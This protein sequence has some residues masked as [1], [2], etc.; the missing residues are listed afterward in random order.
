MINIGEVLLI[1]SSL[2]SLTYVIGAL[3]MALP[4]PLY[5]VKKWGTRL[6]TDGIYA[7]IWTDIYGLTM[8][9]IQYINNL[10]GASWSYYYQWIYAVLVEEVDLYAVIRTAY[11]FA[12]VSQDPAITVFLAPLSFIFSFLTGLI[13]TTET[14]LVISNV[15]YEYTPIFVA[16]GILF[17]SMPFRIGRNIGSSL[18]AFGIV[19]YSA[20]PYLPNFLTS[21]GI[22]VLDLSTSSGNITDTINFL[23]TQA[24]PLLIE[25]T[26]VFPI[27]YLIILSGITIGLGSAISGYSARMPIP[28]E[29]F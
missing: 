3:I 24:I 19:F 15:V 28:I 29:I 6:I 27:A 4:I 10:L 8:Y 26:L 12:S 22:N 16:L 21:L 2:A 13:T 9:I 17:L 1:S 14:L 20:L 18:I 25:G 7:T 11:V 5:G 23:I